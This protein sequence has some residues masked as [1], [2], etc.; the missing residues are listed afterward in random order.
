MS[1]NPF[2]VVTDSISSYSMALCRQH[3][4]P[5][6]DIFFYTDEKCF[7]E[8]LPK[9]DILV[10]STR[11][12]P[13]EMLDK[14]P[15]CRLI[16]K[17][18]TGVNN[19]C[20]DYAASKAV[21]VGNV[22]G[23]NALSVAEYAVALTLCSLRHLTIAHNS[24]VREGK[25]VKST[26][27][28]RCGEL[29][30]KTVGI[31]GFGSIGRTFAELIRGFHCNILYYDLRRLPEAEEEA[32]Q[33]AYC[34]LDDLLVQS[35]IVSLHLPLSEDTRYLINE[36]RLRRMKNLA[37][38][39]NTGRGGLIDEQAL[40]KVLGEGKLLGVALDV[41]EREPVAADD[42]LKDFDRVVMSPHTGAGTRES[43]ERVI[44]QAFININSVLQ[45]HSAARPELI[46]N[47]FKKGD[48]AK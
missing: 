11:A 26:L 38:L 2:V 28:D 42:P 22:A 23:E 24:I 31:V 32:L 21:M 10:T 7:E 4:A 17:L 9:A 48:I 30:G 43:M 40:V 8:S 12:V 47:A 44:A 34:A 6:A 5:S 14:A 46:V 19:I 13:P 36:N 25:W 18:G 16:Q 39:V 29:S 45:T 15:N 27:R 1:R 33:A 3:L 35:D 41:H 37:V 20:C